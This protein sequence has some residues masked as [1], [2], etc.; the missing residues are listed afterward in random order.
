MPNNITTMP[1]CK[2]LGSGCRE[3]FSMPHTLPISKPTASIRWNN[4]H[5]T[6]CHQFHLPF[7]GHK[8]LIWLT[9]AV[10]NKQRALCVINLYVL[11]TTW[12]FMLT[13]THS[14]RLGRLAVVHVE[15]ASNSVYFLLLSK[16]MASHLT[17]ITHRSA[18]KLPNCRTSTMAKHLMLR[19]G[20][21]RHKLC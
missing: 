2:R 15:P 3:I 17:K 14:V 13:K 9:V 6:Q 21:Y 10:S 11:A 4:S 20:K 5:N 8:Y 7:Y 19:G 18:G 1:R 16:N 12:T